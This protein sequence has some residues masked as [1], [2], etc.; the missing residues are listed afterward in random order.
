MM[1]VQYKSTQKINDQS[2]WYSSNKDVQQA[3]SKLADIQKGNKDLEE[4]LNQLNKQI[5]GLQEQ[6]AKSDTSNIKGQLATSRIF[7][8]T[9]PVK[10]PGITLTI[11]D[12]KRD[13][14]SPNPVTHDTDV[15]QIVNELFLSGAEAV[16]VNGERISSATGILCVGPT[17]R[18]N[19]R[20]MTPPY[21]IEAIGQPSTLITGLTMRGGII[22]VL[23]SQKRS[24]QVQGPKESQLITMKGYSGDSSKLTS[25]ATGN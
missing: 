9:S 5:V 19:D 12:S 23:K 6:A 11:D 20:L 17:V 1:A 21:K 25:N 3:T 18:I 14:K 4:R 7:A 10:G 2:G 8:G 13:T 24:L 16:S 22:D 15:M